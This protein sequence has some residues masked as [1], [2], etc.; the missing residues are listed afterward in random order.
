MNYGNAVGVYLNK[1]PENDGTL[2]VAPSTLRITKHEMGHVF[3]VVT[4]SKEYVE[5]LESLKMKHSDT[6][7]G[8]YPK[9]NP[10]GKS[11]HE[12]ETK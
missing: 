3:Y 11:A 4:S 8:H 12:W 2:N 10:S 1:K 7:G 6:Q 9:S 5:Y